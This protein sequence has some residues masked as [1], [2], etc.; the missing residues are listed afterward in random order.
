MLTIGKGETL[1]D[2]IFSHQPVGEITGIYLSSYSKEAMFS[3]S[4][5]EG[6]CYGFWFAYI[7]RTNMKCYEHNDLSIMG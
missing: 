5:D 3:F 4:R 2:A 7:Y 1:D 6:G